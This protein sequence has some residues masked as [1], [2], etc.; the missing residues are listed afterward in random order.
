MQCYSSGTVSVLF[1]QFLFIH[2]SF[3]WLSHMHLCFFLT[4]PVLSQLMLSL[5]IS[6]PLSFHLDF[7]KHF[8]VAV[9]SVASSK[10]HLWFFFLLF[11]P[12]SRSGMRTCLLQRVPARCI[13]S[14][15]TCQRS[16]TCTASALLLF[17]AS[18]KGLFR[19]RR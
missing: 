4:F 3:F 9:V 8:C 14:S 1:P 16:T 17:C 6:F 10:T 13:L 18:S 2:L 19:P 5:L 12:Y 11:L 7:N 15:Q